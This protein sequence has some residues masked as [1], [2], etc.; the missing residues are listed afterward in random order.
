MT[1]SPVSRHIGAQLAQSTHTYTNAHAHTRT[2]IH[3]HQYSH[4]QQRG[5]SSKYNRPASHP[6]RI[7]ACMISG[8]CATSMPTFCMYLSI[9]H[10]S[11]DSWNGERANGRPRT[12]EHNIHARVQCSII[13]QKTVGCGG[14]GI[15]STRTRDASIHIVAKSISLFLFL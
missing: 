6:T 12:N 15:V 14:S 11:K 1:S 8:I 4:R 10:S 5:G 13:Q 3:T 2:H 9:P 7:K